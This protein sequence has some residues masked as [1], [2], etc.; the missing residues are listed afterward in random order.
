MGKSNTP[1]LTA[2]KISRIAK[3]AFASGKRSHLREKNPA[4]KGGI[5]KSHSKGY[6]RIKLAPAD[7]FYAMC[8]SEGY[9]YKHRLVMA[10]FLGRC[11]NETEVSHHRNQDTA[12]NYPSNLKL[13]GSSGEH[14]RIHQVPTHI[15]MN[16]SYCGGQLKRLLWQVMKSLTGR[17]YCNNSCQAKYQYNCGVPTGKGGF[18]QVPSEA[19]GEKGESMIDKGVRYATT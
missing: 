2:L 6:I 12:S 17:F 15:F 10:K 13:I 19:W 8:D 11:L 7:P 18:Y 9:V 16:C 3:E 14:S 1:E 4:W 5:T